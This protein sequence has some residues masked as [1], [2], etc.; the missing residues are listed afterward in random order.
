MKYPTSTRN[1]KLMFLIDI[2]IYNNSLIIIHCCLYLYLYIFYHIFNQVR[3]HVAD[4][5]TNQVRS[6]SMKY[7]TLTQTRC[8]G[9]YL[10]TQNSTAVLSRLEKLTVRRCFFYFFSFFLSFFVGGGGPNITSIKVYEQY[11]CAG[12][13]RG[14]V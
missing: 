10:L 14:K 12:E 4:T 9:L 1:F 5:H 8:S 2:L 7:F 11:P 13:E 3:L 6:T